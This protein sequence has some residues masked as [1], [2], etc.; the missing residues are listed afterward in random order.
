MRWAFVCNLKL[1]AS[2]Q[3]EARKMIVSIG[4]SLWFLCDSVSL[5]KIPLHGAIALFKE[6]DVYWDL[7]AEQ[8]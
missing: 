6:I 2:V 8:I 7:Q 4:N 5:Q 1:L 3:S